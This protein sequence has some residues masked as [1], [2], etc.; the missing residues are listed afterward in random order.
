MEPI[1]RYDG[2][3]EIFNFNVKELTRAGIEL[4]VLRCKEYSNPASEVALD[5]LVIKA[6]EEHFKNEKIISFNAIDCYR[7]ALKKSSR[8]VEKIRSNGYFLPYPINPRSFNQE[9]IL[10][11]YKQENF[12]PLLGMMVFIE[13][14]YE[15]NFSRIKR[16]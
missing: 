5:L 16:E 13:R 4:N 12:N 10:N 7:G 1:A 3:E 8:M 9:D 11:L 2:R 14:E 6:L 15:K